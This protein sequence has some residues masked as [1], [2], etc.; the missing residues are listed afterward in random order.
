LLQNGLNNYLD[1]IDYDQIDEHYHV[2]DE[3]IDQE[4][5]DRKEMVKLSL[6]NQLMEWRQYKRNKYSIK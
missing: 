1:S 5:I 6:K 2:L 4:T 3:N